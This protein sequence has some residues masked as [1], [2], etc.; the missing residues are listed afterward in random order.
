[1]SDMADVHG[2]AHINSNGSNDA[3]AL[4][5][6]HRQ[7]ITGSHILH[8]QNV[9]DAYGHLSFRHPTNPDIFIMSYYVAPA[10]ISSPDDLIAYHVADAEPVDPKS[11][12]GYAER[13]IH[14]ECYKR[15]AGVKSV[16]HSHSEAVTPYSF[17]GVPL[18]PVTHVSGFLSSELPIFEISEAYQEGEEPN[19][20]VTNTHLGAAMAAKLGGKDGA[21]MP[22]HSMVLMR[23]H[24]FTVVAESITDAVVRAVYAQKN[25]VIQTT[26]LLTNAASGG[27][28]GSIRYLSKEEIAATS[29]VLKWSAYRPWD[30]WVREVEANTLYVNRA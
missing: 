7:F 23:G 16:I 12:K 20:L 3:T 15:Y 30:L 6:L 18:R 14:S 5:K 9:L 1:M 4:S 22:E 27:S 28:P 10:N 24:G 26:A 29:K 19:L 17:S 8:N 2:M 25:A 21:E 11:G 13:C